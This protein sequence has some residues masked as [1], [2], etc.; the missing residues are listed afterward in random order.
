VTPTWLITG[1][2]LGS[3]PTMGASLD[4]AVTMWKASSDHTYLLRFHS[5]PCRSSSSSSQHSDRLE[6]WSS[7][8]GGALWRPC[9][10][11]PIHSLTGPVGQPFASLLVSGLRPDD[12]QI[13]NG[14]R[15]FLLELYSYINGFQTH[16]VLVLFWSIEG[17]GPTES[18]CF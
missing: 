4:F 9:T 8:W 10:F 18:S 12:A 3:A 14:T 2:A 5:T 13:H 17:S 6:P 7:C 15:F 11:T 16:R 1:L